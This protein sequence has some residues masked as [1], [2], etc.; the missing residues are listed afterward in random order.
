MEKFCS[1]ITSSPFAD[2]MIVSLMTTNPP[3]RTSTA[4]S[5]LI[6]CKSTEGAAPTGVR[7]KVERRRKDDMNRS[8]RNNA[9]FK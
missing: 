3:P 2:N 4:W 6:T 5:T 7:E 8:N 1:D 9:F